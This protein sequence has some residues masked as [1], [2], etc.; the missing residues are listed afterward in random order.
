MANQQTAA[1]VAHIGAGAAIR[2]IKEQ[3]PEHY[4]AMMAM[5]VLREA[6]EEAY[7]L[8]MA[9]ARKLASIAKA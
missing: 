8:V 4:R 7:R 3:A 1:T 6:D 2:A 5:K 9:L